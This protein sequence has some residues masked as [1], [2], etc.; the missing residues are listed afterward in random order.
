MNFVYSFLQKPKQIFLVHGEPESKEVLG[1]KIQNEAKIPV[2]IPGYG[3]TY[4]LQDE[5]QMTN[6]IQRK[7]ANTVRTEIENRLKKLKEEIKDMEDYV[8][9]DLNDN[10]LKDEDIFR[11]N[12]KIKE[13]EKHILNVIEG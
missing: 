11:I 13:L 1:S 7:V 6:K 3:E 9:Q 8:Y 2:I 10:N 4:D 5:V 12:E